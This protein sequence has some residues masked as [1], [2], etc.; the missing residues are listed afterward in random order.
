[1]DARLNAVAEWIPAAHQQ[2]LALDQYWDR[3]KQVVGPLHGIPFTL[4]DHFSVAGCAVTMGTHSHANSQ[5]KTDGAMHSL[6][7]AAGGVW[8]VL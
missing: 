1:V 7:T 8:C 6:I 3:T 5:A 2:A 4:K